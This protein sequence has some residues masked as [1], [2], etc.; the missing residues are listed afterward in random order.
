MADKPVW[1]RCLNCVQR[2][3][4]KTEQELDDLMRDHIVTTEFGRQCMS[5]KQLSL[6]F[7]KVGN[8]WVKR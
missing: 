6:S 4:G 7:R 5:E 3:E 2:F 1:R 8:A